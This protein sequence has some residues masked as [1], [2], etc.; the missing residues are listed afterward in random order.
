MYRETVI[1]GL[2]TLWVSSPGGAA[3]RIPADGCAD[4]ILRDDE[5]IVAGPSTRWLLARG[6]AELPTVGLRFAPGLAG[7]RLAID[8]SA[9]R[10]RIVPARELL[11]PAV[12]ER[13]HRALR[14]VL[15]E[16]CPAHA[17]SPTERTLREAARALP[18]V[19]GAE[20][21][22]AEQRWSATVRAAARREEP[23]ARLA[24]RLGYSERQ[25]RRRMLLSF[26]FGYAA[27][28]R[29][30]RAED[31][32]RLIRAGAAPAEAAGLAGYADQSHLTR[33]FQRVSG[34]T[35]AQ[36]A[37]AAASGA[38]RSIELPSGSSTVA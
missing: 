17:E 6:S 29:V 35:P 33:E 31:A 23:L 22:P 34:L 28:R 11:A 21:T 10:D 3:A 2:G 38:Y 5:L 19:L 24:D 26:G 36:L 12:A 27:L 20:P 14:S 9:A 18:L 1:P 15:T 8:P 30:L 7:A 37:A 16:R 32:G 25:V 4:I 13:G